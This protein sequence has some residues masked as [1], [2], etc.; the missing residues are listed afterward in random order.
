MLV[1]SISNAETI[2]APTDNDD[3]KVSETYSEIS[4]EVKVKT[5][6]EII[7][8]HFAETPILKRIAVCE[9]E[10]RQYNTDGT[11]LRG[12]MNPLDVGLMQINEKYHLS[13]ATKLGLDIHTLEGNADYAKYLYKTQGVKPWIHSSHCWDPA[14]EF[15]LR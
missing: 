6:E 10:N 3:S 15:A 7:A 12:W 9:S 2:E 11:V 4:E 1:A 13:T 5:T 14:N 8:E